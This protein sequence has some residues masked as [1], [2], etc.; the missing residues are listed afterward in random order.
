VHQIIDIIVV[1]ILDTYR[2]IL[3]RDGYVILNGIFS[4]DWSHLWLPYNGKPNQ[5]RVEKKRYVK[6]VV[7]YLNDSNETIMFNHST[8]G[9]YNYDSFFGN[10]TAEISSYAE[11]ST[12]HEVLHY[13]QI[14]DFN[15]DIVYRID[16]NFC[17]Q[18]NI[19]SRDKLYV[20]INSTNQKGS[21]NK[22]NY[23]SQT[24]SK[25]YPNMW[26]LFFDGS[27]YL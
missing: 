6:H 24:K 23:E 20:Y 15:C 2:I 9:N 1:Y 14:V 18:P 3:S 10:K 26:T 4:S 17:V 22:E 8:L 27:K 25:G 19:V 13:T 11:S 12:Q 16:T 7:T 21:E 5:I